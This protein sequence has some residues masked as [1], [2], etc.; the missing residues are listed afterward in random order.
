MNA[1]MNAYAIV[2]GGSW[3]WALGLSLQ[4]LTHPRRPAH[5]LPL[6]SLTHPPTPLPPCPPPP[7]L[8]SKRAAGADGSDIPAIPVTVRQLEAVIRI[9][10]SLAK[11][12][13]QV[14]GLGD[15]SVAVVGGVQWGLLAGWLICCWG[16]LASPHLPPW[17]LPPLPPACL[18]SSAPATWTTS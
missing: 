10:E 7:C 17:L 4:L 3:I 12:N 2:A 13:L 14:G 8:Q 15:T 6:M 16:I 9:S 11:M 5:C 18:P 1:C